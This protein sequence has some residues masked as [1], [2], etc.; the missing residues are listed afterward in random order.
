MAKYETGENAIGAARLWLLA[1]ALGV[2]P[3][4]FFEGMDRLL[5]ADE[6][7]GETGCPAAGEAGGAA[8]AGAAEAA[9]A[10]RPDAVTRALE[11]QQDGVQLA[12]IFRRISN[13]RTR[14]LLLTLSREL[15][16][17]S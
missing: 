8:S 14:E 16:K 1:R 12:D 11:A 17:N 6:A 5:A 3:G 4:V 15:A 7:A 10:P 13:R 2:A 9:G